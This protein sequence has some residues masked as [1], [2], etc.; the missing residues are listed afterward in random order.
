[1][2]DLVL[3]RREG[4]RRGWQIGGLSATIA[5][6][7]LGGLALLEIVLQNSTDYMEWRMADFCTRSTTLR[8]NE[9]IKRLVG[10]LTAAGKHC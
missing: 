10:V 7:S 4:E 8:A 6:S 5:D 2:A 9:R 3:L 1:M